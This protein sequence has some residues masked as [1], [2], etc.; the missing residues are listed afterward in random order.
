MRRGLESFAERIRVLCGEDWSPLRRGLCHNAQR[1]STIS[2]CRRAV[3]AA[4]DYVRLRS[5]RFA[6]THIHRPYS[7]R[8]GGPTGG[9]GAVTARSSLRAITF[10]SARCASLQLT[11]IAPTHAVPAPLRATWRGR[12]A[13]VAAGDYVRLRLLRFASTHIHRPYP[14]RSGAPADNLHKSLPFERKSLP[15]KT[16]KRRQWICRPP[17]PSLFRLML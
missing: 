14:R 17:T 1:L 3:V 6:P 13:V 11:S 2:A 16:Q 12:R 9:F 5:L 8:S 15:P 10:V 4:G 7:R